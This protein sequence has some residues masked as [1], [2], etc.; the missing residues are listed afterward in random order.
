MLLLD[1]A[2]PNL[3]LLSPGLP[4]AKTL[5]GRE[6]RAAIPSQ[7]VDWRIANA[8]DPR[9]RD[10]LKVAST[11]PFTMGRN[12][13]QTQAPPIKEKERVTPNNSPG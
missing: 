4:P 8:R 2:L 11:L 9:P 3:L 5:P 1:R 10:E 7:D 12:S 6:S 13:P